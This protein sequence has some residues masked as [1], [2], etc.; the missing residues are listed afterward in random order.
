MLLLSDIDRLLF[1]N[2]PYLFKMSVSCINYG[3]DIA[4][5]C[6]NDLDSYI[7]NGSF[8]N[9]SHNLLI[10]D[11][12]LSSYILKPFISCPWRHVRVVTKRHGQLS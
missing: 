12:P 9:L 6:G 2:I 3:I 7:G 11:T 4:S 5:F 10:S 1:S 8:F